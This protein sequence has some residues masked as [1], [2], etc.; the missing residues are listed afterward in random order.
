MKSYLIRKLSRKGVSDVPV[1]DFDERFY[2][3]HYPDLQNL[4]GR[5]RLLDHYV[6]HGR[7]EGRFPTL[8]KA[9][10]FYKSNGRSIPQD[11]DWQ[12]YRQLNPDL[13]RLFIDSW[14]YTLHYV[15]SGLDERRPYTLDSK[16][17][18]ERWESELD[19]YEFTLNSVAIGGQNIRSRPAAIELF[20]R[21]GIA[22]I[23]PLSSKLYFEP[24]FY[25][26]NYDIAMTSPED[27]YRHWLF[28]GFPSGF[29]P[30]E[31]REIFPLMGGAEYPKCFDWRSFIGL[32]A[33][34]KTTYP[35]KIQALRALFD[36][37]AS[38]KAQ[39]FVSAPGSSALYSAIGSY[40]LINRRHEKAVK[41][42]NKSLV[43]DQTLAKPY[44][45]RG[46]A[47]R[48]LHQTALAL[49]DYRKAMEFT[50]YSVWA[51]VNLGSIY[52]SEGEHEK[53][54][55]LFESNYHRWAGTP[56]F[57][58]A[59]D[60]LVE[61]HFRV[62]GDE[63]R[64]TLRIGHINDANEKADYQLRRL[65]SR[66]ESL[67]VTKAH[68]IVGSIQASNSDS[69]G[70]RIIILAC[71][72]IPQCTRYRVQQKVE[73]LTSQGVSVD[74]FEMNDTFAF[75]NSVVGATA[76]IFYRVPAFPK[77]IESILYTRALGIPTFYDVD[78]LIFTTAF[79]DKYESYGGQ[80]T[81]DEYVGLQYGV[82]LYRHALGLCDFGISS[83]SPLADQ[84]RPYVRSNIVYVVA[85]A[86][87]SKSAFSLACGNT[88]RLIGPEIRIFY[89]SGTKAHNEDFNDIVGPALLDILQ[90]HNNVKLVV[91]GYIN[92]DYRFKT[93]MDRVDCIPFVQNTDQYSAIL[94][95]CDI[96]ISVLRAG[97]MTD[98][99]S[100]IKWLEASVLGIPSIV[101]RTAVFSRIIT[102]GVDGMLAADHHQWMVA[103]DK[104]LKD[105]VTRQKVGEA[106]RV[107]ALKD[108]GSSKIGL[109]LWKALSSSFKASPLPDEAPPLSLPTEAR[110]CVLVC[111]VF[112]APQSHG[113]ATRVV[114]DNVNYFLDHCSKDF[115]IA[116]VATDDRMPIGQFRQENYRGCRLFRI[117]TPQ[118]INMDWRPFNN[119]NEDPYKRVLDLI[120]PA[121]V[122]FH[123]IQRL[124][125]SIV[126][127]TME[128][129]I[130]YII[131][132][133]DT[134]WICDYQF[135]I[136]RENMLVDP[137]ERVF[138]GPLPDG[139]SKTD[140]I[141]RR[142]RLRMLLSAARYVLPVSLSFSKIHEAIGLDNIRV[143][144]NGL[145]KLPPVLPSQQNERLTFGHI[146]GRS[147]HKGASLIETVLK[148][149]R[150][151][152]IRL[153][154]ID[155]MLE[156]GE[157][158]TETWGETEVI[159]QGQ[160][161]QDKINELFAS[162]DVLLAPSIWP[163][164]HGLVTREALFYGKWVVASDR[165]AI[166]DDV[167]ESINGFK[168]DVSSPDGLSNVLSMM[169]NTIGSFK[170]VAVPKSAV[171]SSD[172]QALEL[173][174]L[175]SAVFVG[176]IH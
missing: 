168:V 167:E 169:N 32:K 2:Q 18:E 160:Y 154:M 55:E 130:P 129:N 41:A 106:A 49:S 84:M 1:S 170:D 85:N 81:Y 77:V 125:A 40:H 88:R 103:F 96:N 122:H 76:A 67:K 140:S 68:G 171:R 74:V 86:L 108:Y 101:S 102:D 59:I 83:T 63:I 48:N 47:H 43:Y 24:V 100:E 87:D 6:S 5:R 52:S 50:Q 71:L 145:S 75:M 82:P 25:K 4:T 98:C 13:Q 163:E 78:D 16:R 128:R 42:Y 173:A 3:I 90:T 112:F 20:K 34:H 35:F 26:E 148:K 64:K 60:N 19:L 69:V 157:E 164:S 151:S 57:R 118:E 134:W 99:K 165:G 65:T 66:I 56:E 158:V 70:G 144:K 28:E 7:R 8:E 155:G 119:A 44:L 73:Q 113:G 21:F 176:G 33:N 116:I 149:N 141:E 36:S 172:G 150:F 162:F 156:Y 136:D 175:Y 161:P 12:V 39:Q 79:P 45:L 89:G 123:C 135:M 38:S 53:A 120:K 10:Q 22:N 143:I 23:V 109:D 54:F 9:L 61:S 31:T 93:L 72:D 80:I 46:D 29:Q 142:Q 138:S 30:N 97:L 131:T 121:I 110:P 124:T 95:T 166:A 137:A 94:S 17:P 14:Q 62:I 146:G 159:L 152:K 127:I 51:I 133:H 117:A 91:V 132:L 114:E 15:A 139:V 126:Q 27:L 115:D 111:N 11:F 174:E 58:E 37:M 147:P 92:L 153:V 107:K 105:V 104:L